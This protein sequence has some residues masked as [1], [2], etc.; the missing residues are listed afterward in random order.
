MKKITFVLVLFALLGFSQANASGSF[1]SNYLVLFY[2]SF[3]FVF[4]LLI[5][6]FCSTAKFDKLGMRGKKQ[7]I[8]EIAK[9][10]MID[11]AKVMI[12]I[13]LMYILIEV[14]SVVTGMSTISSP[15]VIVIKDVTFASPIIALIVWNIWLAFIGGICLLFANA[16]TFIV[17]N[18]LLKIT[19]PV[20]LIFISGVVIAYVGVPILD[21]RYVF[22][23]D[24]LSTLSFGLTTIQLLMVVICSLAK[25]KYSNNKIVRNY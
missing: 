23:A 4:V 11:G 2:G 1:V 16:I 19:L 3:S 15:D 17:N 13:S 10:S 12:T 8:S 25:I 22:S 9:S 6:M 20:L 24:A 21:L 5:T 7:Y 14:F 18:H